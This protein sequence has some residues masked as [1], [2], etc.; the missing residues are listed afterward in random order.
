MVLIWCG[1]LAFRTTLLEKIIRFV[2]FCCCKKNWNLWS[3]LLLVV[4][5]VLLLLHFCA[6]MTVNLR[7]D[8]A[9]GL[10]VYHLSC[11]NVL[12]DVKV[13]LVQWLLTNLF[14]SMKLHI[15]PSDAA[16]AEA[17]KGT[18]K[19]WR[20]F[21]IICNNSNVIRH[22]K[23]SIESQTATCLQ[24]AASLWVVIVAAWY[25]SNRRVYRH[26]GDKTFGRH[27]FGL[28]IFRWPFGRHWLDV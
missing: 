20:C 10:M 6:G 12:K 18:E 2:D 16:A 13:W 17:Q 28:H 21:I 19:S 22:R 8:L 5:W 23:L 15:V 3:I 1:Y 9:A 14:L 25:R 11:S 4:Q 27:T 24:Q 26:L 7:A